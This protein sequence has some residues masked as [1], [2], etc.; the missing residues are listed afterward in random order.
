MCTK[1]SAMVIFLYFMEKKKIKFSSSS[2]VLQFRLVIRISVIL[3]KLNY[4]SSYIVNC[5]FMTLILK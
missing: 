5:V 1:C 2:K 4:R 3:Y